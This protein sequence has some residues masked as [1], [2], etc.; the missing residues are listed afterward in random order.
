MKVNVKCFDYNNLLHDVKFM[1]SIVKRVM[2]VFIKILRCLNSNFHEFEILKKV[3]ITKTFNVD[4][5]N[6]FIKITLFCIYISI[7]SRLLSCTF[8]L[9][10]YDH[11]LAKFRLQIQLITTSPV[12]H[13]LSYPHSPLFWQAVKNSLGLMPNI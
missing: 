10:V 9:I 2:D 4:F 3:I 7:F 5:L 11:M 6:K 13:F 1:K 12:T 8:N